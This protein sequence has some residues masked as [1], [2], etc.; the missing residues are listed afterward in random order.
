MEREIDHRHWMLRFAE[1]ILLL[2]LDPEPGDV[3][4][5]PPSV[6]DHVFV[7][8]VLM[9]L[10]H[11]NRIGVDLRSYQAFLGVCAAES[12]FIGGFESAVG[13]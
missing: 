4:R 7:G 11:L 6:V 10:E 8:S 12:P 5:V 3:V 2:V 13:L 9:D 1:E